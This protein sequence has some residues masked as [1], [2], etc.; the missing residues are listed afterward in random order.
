[1]APEE[2]LTGV[3]VITNGDREEELEIP[4]IGVGASVNTT[5]S[6]T[7][8]VG[9]N[10]PAPPS[11]SYLRR[12]GDYLNRRRIRTVSDQERQDQGADEEEEEEELADQR[13]EILEQKSGQEG[14]L[15]NVIYRDS[16]VM[17]MQQQHQ[18]LKKTQGLFVIC[19]EENNKVKQ[20]SSSSSVI[21]SSDISDVE[22]DGI[23]NQKQDPRTSHNGY[24]LPRVFLSKEG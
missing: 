12:L 1:M 5:P 20:S 3:V 18:K 21:T 23:V 4:S 8:G 11:K 16:E 19:D 22:L 24:L 6:T 7:A 14:D 10:A 15:S 17:K 13:Q 2:A 9:S